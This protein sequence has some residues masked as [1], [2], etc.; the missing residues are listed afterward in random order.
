M[1]A[2]FS[3][4]R[5]FASAWRAAAS[6]HARTTACRRF[7]RETIA[8]FENLTAILSLGAI[9]HQSVVRA[10]DL[11]VGAYP[12]AH[13]ARYQ[14]DGLALF[15]SYHCSRYNTNTGRLTDEMFEAVVGEV[16]ELLHKST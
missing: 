6:R 14:T 12:F 11:R 1:R 10:L 15:S 5:C 13:G 4:G 2:S 16:A 3:T 8:R 7:L 9:A